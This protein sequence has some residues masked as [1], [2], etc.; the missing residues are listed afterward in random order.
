M[1]STTLEFSEDYL[2]IPFYYKCDN[3]LRTCIAEDL[4]KSYGTEEEVSSS[5]ATSDWFQVTA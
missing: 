1:L 3:L 5:H 4:V 2:F